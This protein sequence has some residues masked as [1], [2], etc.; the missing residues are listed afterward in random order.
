MPATDTRGALARK[1]SALIS[2]AESLSSDDEPAANTGPTKRARSAGDHHSDGTYT[3]AQKQKKRAKAGKATNKRKLKAKADRFTTLPLDP[4]FEILWRLDATDLV[5]LRETCKSFY[6]LLSGPDGETVWAHALAK[7][8]L[9]ELEAGLLEPWQYAEMALSGRCTKGGRRQFI[10]DWSVLRR[11]CR[12]C[13]KANLF[14]LDQIKIK[15]ARLNQAS[16]TGNAFRHDFETLNQYLWSLQAQDDADLSLRPAGSR[17]ITRNTTSKR[18]PDVPLPQ[19][20]VAKFVEE[21][22]NIKLLVEQVGHTH[23]Y[24]NEPL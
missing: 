2:Y 15:P 21:R 16:A 19:S 24:L 23:A 6:R 10:P 7:A 1:S 8:E 11:Y 3:G 22:A 14:R 13:R 12:T 4:L 17:S 20:R 18:S 5:F 9:P